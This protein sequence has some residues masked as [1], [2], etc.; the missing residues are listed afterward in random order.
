VSI[1]DKIFATFGLVGVV[2]G[3][4][5]F[6]ATWALPRLQHTN[7]YKPSMF[8]GDLPPT[9]ANRVLMSSYFIAIGA[10]ITSSSTDQRLISWLF[11]ICTILCVIKMSAARKRNA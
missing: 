9:N 5:G 7:L 11:L 3:I 10:W 8:T 1:V 6:V 4:G 2:Y